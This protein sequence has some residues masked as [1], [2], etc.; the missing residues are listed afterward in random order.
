MN[1]RSA[2][3][4]ALPL[5]PRFARDLAVHGAAVALVT[6]TGEVSYADLAERAGRFARRLGGGRKLLALE[7]AP[8]AD[9]VAA[10]LGA[11]GA[12]HVVALLP[13]AEA[14]AGFRSRFQPDAVFARQ[15]GRW[16]L[17]LDGRDKPALHPDLAVVM[18]TSGST[19]HGKAVRLSSRAVQENADAIAAFQGLTAGERAA[20][21]LPLHYSYGLSVLNS[22]LSVG[23]SVWLAEGG[24]LQPGFLAALRA[25]RATSLAAV[26]H[27][28]QV[29]A[30]LGFDQADLPDLRL[31]TSAGGA[32]PVARMR[33]LGRMM[34][35]RGGRFLA[36]YGQTEATARIAYLPPE[37]A[38]RVEK[39]GVIGVAVPGGRLSLRDGELVYDGP[40]VMMGYATDRAD[41]ARGSEVGALATGDLA[42]IG[43]DGLFRITGR[44]RRM[45]KIAGLR[46]G[47]DA[48]EA[49]LAERGIPAAVWGDDTRLCVA[50]EG[51]ADVASV[52]AGLTGLTARHVSLRH[53]PS[54][55]RL[56]NGKIDYPRLA[57]G[58]EVAATDIAQAFAQVFHPV[59]VSPDDSFA[60]LGGDSL[61]HVELAMVL[62]TRLGHLPE[63]W[64][65]MSV[66]RLAALAT[67]PVPKVA[68]V[69]TA[70]VMRALAV[71]AV[72]L[73]HETL[74]PL[75]G[76]AAVMVVLIGLMLARFQRAAMA[77]GRVGHLLRP[78]GRVLA[79]YYLILAGYAVAWGQIPWGSALLVSNFGIGAPATFDRLPFLYWF[80]EAFAQ[81][82]LVLAV[83]VM[84]PPLRRLIGRDP[85]RFGLWFL[86]GALALRFVFPLVWDIGGQ[87]IFTL[88]WVLYLAALGWLVGVARGRQR[89]LVLALAAPVLALVAL[90]GGNWYGA[91][92]KYG[93]VL[94]VIAL[95]LFV[96]QMRLPAWALRP[97]LA[98][99][100]AS[101]LIY[102]THRFVPNLLL[103]P[104][105]ADMPAWL[106]SSLSVAGGIGI[107][108]LAFAAQRA[109]LRLWAK[110]RP[111]LHPWTNTLGA[112]G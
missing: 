24:L 45:S 105:V 6:A 1:A 75:Y 96:P 33:Q 13:D 107:G 79:P 44:A 97:V 3:D 99:A 30:R 31:L 95:L 63:G 47:H 90:Y 103:A 23:A 48:V 88:A 10:Y 83:L 80:V 70:L 53:M 74:W 20:L 62:E 91:W 35:A 100:G 16:R 68:T 73:T 78:L 32:M 46:I 7:A 59:I 93:S 108:L 57:S 81:M 14:V 39:H 89:L 26:P 69:D 54:L 4:R 36:M 58:P 27:G 101:Y 40:G 109:L 94:A 34:A 61:R 8:S 17:V 67:A 64:E 19:G 37:Q 25:V 15:G 52:V 98:V 5:A 86:G 51:Q 66:A 92:L 11:L 38:A 102:L 29:L 65:A 22:H 111:P 84:L 77:E 9:F 18:M 104:F 28:H 43:P 112:R 110:H 56:A 87:R 49:A 82:M 106:F 72:V 71:L 21:V 42:E 2:P 50:A 76:G 55:P 85:F 41:L 12:G 60:A